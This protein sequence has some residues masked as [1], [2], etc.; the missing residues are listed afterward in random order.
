MTDETRRRWTVWGT[1][2][3]QKR[4]TTRFNGVNR[5]SLDVP[6]DSVQIDSM[7]VIRGLTGRVGERLMAW[8]ERAGRVAVL[9]ALLSVAAVGSTSAQVIGKPWV[10]AY[11]FGA[12]YVADAPNMLVGGGLFVV[13]P[14]FGGFG[15][16]VD[17]K[18]S[19]GSPGRESS[20]NPDLTAQQVMDLYTDRPYMDK[21]AWHSVNVALI[22]PVTSE[23]MVYLG[24][25]MTTRDNYAEFW[26][27]TQTRGELGYYWVRKMP[28]PR[29]LPNVMG[30][31][32][33][34]LG[35]NVNAMFGIETA[36]KGFSVGLFLVFPGAAG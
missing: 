2:P 12:G 13:T 27:P 4:Y 34:R 30:G 18:M 23:L 5:G 20:Y 16:Y 10:P 29:H 14:V 6:T 36:P 28:T 32:L 1:R 33:L 35:S 7:D 25:G 11:R 9:V 26:D 17:L 19:G 15:L 21:S 22:R 3:V 8:T 24:A 31:M